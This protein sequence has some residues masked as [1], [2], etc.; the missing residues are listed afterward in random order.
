MAG[1][2]KHNF[3]HYE[4]LPMQK[5]RSD[6]TST[7]SELRVPHHLSHITTHDEPGQQKTPDSCLSPALDGALERKKEMEAWQQD[8]Q[9]AG[10]WLLTRHTYSELKSVE[11][12]PRWEEEEEDGREVAHSVVRE[13][14]VDWNARADA[15]VPMCADWMQTPTSARLEKRRSIRNRMQRGVSDGYVFALKTVAAMRRVGREAEP[16]QGAH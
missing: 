5:R 10:K 11:D 7:P 3:T 2:R 13:T 16:S 9:A 15:I 1:T 6:Q 14:Q 8:W 4:T 12:E